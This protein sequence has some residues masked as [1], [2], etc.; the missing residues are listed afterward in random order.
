MITIN[1]ATDPF[2]DIMHEHQEHLVEEVHEVVWRIPE[3]NYGFA[4]YEYVWPSFAKLCALHAT[5]QPK[6]IDKIWSGTDGVASLIIGL[7]QLLDTKT[8]RQYATKTKG[9]LNI[10]SG[11]QV[12]VILAV[13]SPALPFACAAVTI[14]DL[15]LSLDP[16]IYEYTRYTSF[17]FWLHDRIHHLNHIVEREQGLFDEQ[18]AFEERVSS[19]PNIQYQAWIREQKKTRLD[20]I[21]REKKDVIQS[22]QTRLYIP[23]NKLTA[24]AQTM[25]KEHAVTFKFER[26][27]DDVTD[28]AA[29]EKELLNA[30]KTKFKQAFHESFIFSCAAVGWI[31]VCIPGLQIPGLIFIAAAALLYMHKN[32]DC[33]MHYLNKT[34]ESIPQTIDTNTN[35]DTDTDIGSDEVHPH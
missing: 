2:F 4:L 3:I 28:Y 23:E 1:Q 21:Q 19:N 32:I 26:P 30:I 34:Q 31:L 22:I 13:L 27:S 6:I 12:L 20:D 29:K 14:N 33:L 25:I 8:H 10:G 17:E 15:M 11:V 24:E 35:T 9:L 18:Q 16:L 5:P 7:T